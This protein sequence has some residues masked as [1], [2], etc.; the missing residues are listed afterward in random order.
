M[1]SYNIYPRVTSNPYKIKSLRAVLPTVSSSL[2]GI[3]DKEGITRYSEIF[4]FQT[5]SMRINKRTFVYK[6][7]RE[8][9]C[10]CS[11]KELLNVM[12]VAMQLNFEF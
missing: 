1:S 7:T 10:Y 12:E 5:C 4:V 9:L 3:K 11:E 6:L 8:S 2:K